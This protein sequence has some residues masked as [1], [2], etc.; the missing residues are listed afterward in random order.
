MKRS[1]IPSVILMILKEI[2]AITVD[3]FF[4]PKYAKKYGYTPTNFSKNNSACRAAFS[5]L[6]S[7]NFIKQRG[8][9]YY[10]TTKGEKEVFFNYLKNN[11]LNRF[12]ENENKKWDGKWRIMFFDIP[13][14][15]RKYRDELRL[16]LKAIGFKEFQ[17]SVWIYPYKVPDLLKEIL[18]E[19]K[20]KHYVRLI[21]TMDIEYDKDWKRVFKI[22]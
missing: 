11:N 3:A 18:F 6:K 17:K 22:E 15:K 14:K 2:G 13:E 5:R 16:M 21:T 8:A 4:N 10:L 20:M 19:E 7:R 9:I 12:P 1:S